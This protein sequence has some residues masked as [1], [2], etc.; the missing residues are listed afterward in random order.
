VFNF[1][2]N[3]LPYAPEYQVTVQY[4]HEFPL[5]SGA[6]IVPRIRASYYDDMFLGWENRTDR[7]AGT[8][9]ATDPGEKDFG[10]QPAYTMLDAAIAFRSSTDQWTA[11]AFITNALDEA[12]KTEAFYGTPRTFYSWGQRRQVGVRLAYKYK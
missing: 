11:E 6:A 10:L 7:P 5:P 1:A 9:N 8:L 4:S 2:G 3:N 12:V